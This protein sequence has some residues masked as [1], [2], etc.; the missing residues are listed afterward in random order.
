MFKISC[1]FK[2]ACLVNYTSQVHRA[3]M[4]ELFLISSFLGRGKW[5]CRWG[6]HHW[7]WWQNRNKRETRERCQARRQWNTRTENRWKERKTK[8]HWTELLLTSPMRKRQ[9][10]CHLKEHD[11]LM[12][13]SLII[14]PNCSWSF[15]EMKL[16]MLIE[17]VKW[18]KNFISGIQLNI[19]RQISKTSGNI[20]YIIIIVDTLTLIKTA[21]F[22]YVMHFGY[23]KDMLDSDTKWYDIRSQNATK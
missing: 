4:R 15:T 8:R 10:R 21:V 19:G 16:T 9:E 22:G 11:L 23:N 1:D 20:F 2:L 13:G 14:W 3:I 12:T 17:I 7:Y 6:R 5:R 18:S